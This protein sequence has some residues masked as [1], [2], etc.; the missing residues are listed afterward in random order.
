MSTMTLEHGGAEAISLSGLAGA[1]AQPAAR[2]DVQ[3][4]AGLVW[5]GR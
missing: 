2:S 5:Q 3:D 4:A 1:P